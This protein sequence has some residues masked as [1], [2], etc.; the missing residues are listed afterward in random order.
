[1]CSA[2]IYIDNT[3]DLGQLCIVFGDKHDSKTFQSRLLSDYTSIIDIAWG[4]LQI[5]YFSMICFPF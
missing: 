4:I 2:D 3:F 1:M 5:W